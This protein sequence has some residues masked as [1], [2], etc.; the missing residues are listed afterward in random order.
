M[1]KKKKKE[2]NQISLKQML[3]ILQ[4]KDEKPVVS[5]QV[6]LTFF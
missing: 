6:S 3:V 1:G 2:I 5:F 4:H